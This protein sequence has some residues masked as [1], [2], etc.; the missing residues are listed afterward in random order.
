[1]SSPPPIDRGERMLLLEAVQSKV[2]GSPWVC[3]QAG[4]PLTPLN[5]HTGQVKSMA[6]EPWRAPA[7]T[8]CDDGRRKPCPARTCV[9]S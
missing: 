2:R 3:R 9:T 4:Q 5:G 7:T 6:L 1:M 8:T